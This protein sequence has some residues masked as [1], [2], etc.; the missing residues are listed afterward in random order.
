MN[1][2]WLVLCVGFSV[3]FISW[4]NG[5]EIWANCLWLVYLKMGTLRNITKQLLKLLFFWGVSWSS[6]V[7]IQCLFSLIVYGK[8]MWVWSSVW[9]EELW[10]QE[11]S[12][13]A[14]WAFTT[15]SLVSS[16]SPP[17]PSSSASFYFCTTMGKACITHSYTILHACCINDS[18][19]AYHHYQGVKST[20]PWI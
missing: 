15:S 1:V 6:L 20:S 10:N 12:F 13:S 5:Y 3:P 18:C 4:V 11:S 14:L 19:S 16:T 17:L 2:A 9:A 7:D 8:K